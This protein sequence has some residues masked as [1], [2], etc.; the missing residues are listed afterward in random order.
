MAKIHGADLFPILSQQPIGIAR[1]AAA[2]KH[3]DDGHLIEFKALEARSILNRNI[4]R[5]TSWIA[6]NINP[7]RR[8]EGGCKGGFARYTLDF[9]QPISIDSKLHKQ[10]AAK[11][12]PEEP[13]AWATAFEHEI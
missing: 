7:Y 12:A 1:L 13:Q 6:Y 3:A 10:P 9:W 5:R 4:S 2:A 8:C 11:T